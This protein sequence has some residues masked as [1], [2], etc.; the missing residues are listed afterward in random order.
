M[1]PNINKPAKHEVEFGRDEHKIWHTAALA[2]ATNAGSA[3]QV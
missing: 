1:P 3:G 2:A